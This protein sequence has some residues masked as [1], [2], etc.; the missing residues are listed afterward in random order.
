MYACAQAMG[1]GVCQVI[2]PFLVPLF[3]L[4]W[5]GVVVLRNKA[6]GKYV[7]GTGRER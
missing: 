3:G 4:I 7:G 2:E 5:C 6:P 1:R